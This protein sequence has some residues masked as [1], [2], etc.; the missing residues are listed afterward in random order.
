MWV[1]DSCAAILNEPYKKLQELAEKYG[2]VTRIPTLSEIIQGI[3]AEDSRFSEEAY[4]VVA[5]AAKSAFSELLLKRNAKPEGFSLETR[6]DNEGPVERFAYVKISSKHLVVALQR[7][8]AKRFGKCATATFNSWGVTCWRDFAEVVSRMQGKFYLFE[9][10]V[11]NKEDFRSRG[12]LDDV[13][14]ET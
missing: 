11:S 1:C 3:V 8:A 5:E 2:T 4:E 12:A 10:F 6:K 14:P 9:N 7:L 13:F